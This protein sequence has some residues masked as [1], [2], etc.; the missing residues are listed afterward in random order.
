MDLSLRLS[1]ATDRVR[2]LLWAWPAGGVVVGLVLGNVLA[3]HAGDPAVA[4]QL[5]VAGSPSD[6]RAL[7]VGILAAL[8][9]AL[10]VAF[11]L[12]L[13]AIQTA[14]T[15][16]GPRLLRN[17]LR[18]PGTQVV[19]VLLLGTSSYCL[20]VVLG[21][22]EETVPRVAA[23]GGV[24]LAL[25]SVGAIA[26]F[27][28]H[29]AESLR[30]ESVLAR[31]TR[32]CTA[33]IDRVTATRAAAGPGDLPVL[34]P[35][36]PAGAAV[37]ASP[38]TGYLQQV[39]SDALTALAVR[40]DVSVRVVPARGEQVVAG[41][42]LAWVWP[43]AAVAPGGPVAFGHEL[44]HALDLGFER[45]LQQDIGF[46][47]RQVVD[48]AIKAIS[49]AVNDPYSAVQALDHLEQ[50]LVRL[51]PFRLGPQVHSAGDGQV[52][53][54]PALGFDGYLALACDQVRRY[55]ADEPAVVARLLRLLRTVAASAPGLHVP[56]LHAQV[57]AVMAAAEQQIPVL[58]DVEPLRAIAAETRSW[59]DGLIAAS[60]APGPLLL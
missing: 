46:G 53:A 45:T 25:L 40:H 60:A 56:A 6:V 5:L 57:D 43:A 1:S 15:N 13:V 49:P 34:L 12:T 37:I 50:L 41:A 36:P 39:F 8:I 29:I 4:E 42:P 19:L 2:E 11:S 27:L 55:G 3:A 54:V 9:T 16:Y 59:I 26:Y 23:T 17:Y 35:D 33:T 21:A 18:D 32:E 51:A 38:D 14:G 7:M 22:P 30:V 28:G 58:R 24:L 48:L 52:V 20:G 44:R 47:F 31:V 10:S